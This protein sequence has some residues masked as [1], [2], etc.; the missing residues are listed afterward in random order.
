MLSVSTTCFCGVTVRL[1][2]KAFFADEWHNELLFCKM[3]GA[4]DETTPIG[5]D[6]APSDRFAD[7]ISLLLDENPEATLLGL[8]FV[9][10]GKSYVEL[11]I[12]STS[13]GYH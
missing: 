8:D 4:L 13:A 7:E 6:G 5:C 2:K 12:L 3:L 10:Y 11:M 9:W 1:P